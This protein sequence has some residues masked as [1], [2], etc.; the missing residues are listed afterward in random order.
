MSASAVTASPRTSAFRQVAGPA[1]CGI[2]TTAVLS[3][4]IFVGSRTL[5]HFDAALVGYTF[6]VLFATF[7]LTYRY[8]MWL[9]RPPTA[10]YWRRGWQA[11]FRRGWRR[12]N[13][14]AW[15]R[16]VGSDAL[17]NASSSRAIP[18]VGSCTCSSCGAASSPWPSRFLLSSVAAF[19]PR[20]WRPVSVRG[21]PLRVPC[22]PVSA[23]LGDR[24][25][26]LPRPGVV[27]VPGNRR[28]DAGR[29]AAHAG[30]GRGCGSTVR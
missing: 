16:R 2:G 14:G 5:A 21:G 24:I 27:V 23:R 25:R 30:R 12:R 10:V 19:S 18:C 6:S 29:A 15:F 9:R 13:A 3:L 1:A 8:A 17:A 4:L 28:R 20:A 22:L 7:G 11:F 26:P